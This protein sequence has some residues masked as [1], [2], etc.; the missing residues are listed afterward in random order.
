MATGRPPPA[1]AS[2]PS[3]ASSAER[4]QSGQLRR[5]QVGQRRRRAPPASAP[6]PCSRAA[7]SASASGRTSNGVPVMPCRQSTPRPSPAIESGDL[8]AGSGPETLEHGETLSGSRSD[9]RRPKAKATVRASV[10]AR[11]VALACGQ[12]PGC[13][14][15]P[16]GREA[17]R[18][19]DRAVLGVVVGPR[20]VRRP[21]SCGPPQ[22]I[23]PVGQRSSRAACCRSR[24]SSGAR[25]PS[26]CSCMSTRCST[27]EHI[28]WPC[29]SVWI[30]AGD[31]GRGD[32]LA[33]LGGDGLHRAGVARVADRRQNA[34]LE[35]VHELGDA[36]A[37]IA[38]A[39]V[40]RVH[41]RLGVDVIP[42]GR[43]ARVLDR[44]PEL[45]GLGV[46]AA[47]LGQ[48]GHRVRRR[49]RR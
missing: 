35:G 49:R 8:S 36:D 44:R 39:A 23:P 40:R 20:R 38:E 30:C 43:A 12:Q 47:R 18:A 9:S 14:F 2:Q 19:V 10:D 41:G 24:R 33:Q 42:A 7:R 4:S 28:G 48:P 32:E 25:C 27:T 3:S 11:I 15:E 1:R 16:A 31:A 37:R 21:L 26:C 6:R 22:L 45:A 17:D 46:L 29:E 5:R 34:V 13:G